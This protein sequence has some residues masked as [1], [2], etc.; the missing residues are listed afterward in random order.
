MPDLFQLSWDI[1]RSGLGGIWQA[2]ELTIFI[3]KIGGVQ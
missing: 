2:R 1:G 3:Y